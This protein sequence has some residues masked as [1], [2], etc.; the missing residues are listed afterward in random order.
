MRHRLT[1][2]S[3]RFVTATRLLSA[4][5]NRWAEVS[6]V[7]TTQETAL[8]AAVPPSELRV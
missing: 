3:G 2:R 4:E 6:D 7:K 5:L 8:R 1:S